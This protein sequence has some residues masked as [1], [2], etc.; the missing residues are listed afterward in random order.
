MSTKK[1]RKAP[2]SQANNL[3]LI[4]NIFC[5]FENMGMNKYDIQRKYDLVERE[6]A[7]YLDALD[8]LQ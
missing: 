8:R 4:Y 2:F 3:G 7:Y 6:G 1:L 5:N